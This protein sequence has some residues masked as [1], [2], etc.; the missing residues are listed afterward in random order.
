VK[1]EP[2][3]VVVVDDEPYFRQFVATVLAQ[4]GYDVREA[5][6]AREALEL[7]EQE[8]PGAVVLDVVLPGV[9]G[10]ELCRQLRDR[11]G[12]ALPIIFV[13]GERTEALDSVAGL[14][15]GADDYLEKPFDP[16]ELVA[17]VRRSIERATAASTSGSAREDST[18]SHSLTPREIEVLEVLVEGLGTRAI[19]ERLFI[20]EK[21]VA[22]HVQRILTKLGVHSRAAAVAV[23]HRESLVFEVDAHLALTTK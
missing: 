22:T 9:S 15:I 12:S 1:N 2:D 19:G 13:S 6:S 23:A 3:N 16:G 18:A 10:Y 8:R 17:R 14:L 5:A 7:I 20:S 11:F 4:A 21:T